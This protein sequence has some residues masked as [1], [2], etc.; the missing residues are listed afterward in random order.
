MTPKVDLL[1]ALIT[2]KQF[3]ALEFIKNL[4]HFNLLF[5]IQFSTRV[6][7]HISHT[8]KK[9]PSYSFFYIPKM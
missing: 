9:N 5:H 3:E 6:T 2:I 4:N 7:D 8:S 1:R